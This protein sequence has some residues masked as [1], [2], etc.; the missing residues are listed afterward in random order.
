MGQE[1]C[2]TTEKELNNLQVENPEEQIKEKRPSVFK[3]KSK[4][5][6]EKNLEKVNIEED[7]DRDEDMAMVEKVKQ[8][9]KM[10][11]YKTKKSP[12]LLKLDPP[13]FK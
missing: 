12:N 9:M 13:K 5:Y 2:S 4:S 6:N 7:E 1:C 3:L 10:P 11:S 8:K